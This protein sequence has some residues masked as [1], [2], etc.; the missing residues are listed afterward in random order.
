MPH[1]HWQLMVLGVDPDHHGRGLGSA[2]VA[3]GIERA[4]SDRSAIYVDTSAEINV[5]FYER[6]GF[7]VIEKT[8]VTDLHMP[9]WM[10][11][12]RPISTD[13]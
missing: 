2:L 13:T 11:V 8:T 10:M 5:G 1:P 3:A 9:F 12:R 7:E 6:F 4:N